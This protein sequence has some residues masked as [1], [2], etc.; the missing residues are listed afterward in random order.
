[1]GAH[2]GAGAAGHA[3]GAC[4]EDLIWLGAQKQTMDLLMQ[5]VRLYSAR[6]GAAQHAERCKA[7]FRSALALSQ[8]HAGKRFLQLLAEQH[9]NHNHS[10]CAAASSRA[11]GDKS[12]E[13]D[14]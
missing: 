4:D 11:G 14:A 8:Q 10:D 7:L 9:S 12:E 13:E 3:D 6:K 5:L 1:V 2:A